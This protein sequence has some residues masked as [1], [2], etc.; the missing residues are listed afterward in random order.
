VA[1]DGS[2]QYTVLT[3][4]SGL[5]YPSLTGLRNGLVSVQTLFQVYRFGIVRGVIYPVSPV[6]VTLATIRYGLGALPVAD[7]AWKQ[8][9]QEHETGV[10]LQAALERFSRTL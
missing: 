8:L 9:L 1:C 7:P 10:F 6:F 2:S 5:K 4:P 3:H